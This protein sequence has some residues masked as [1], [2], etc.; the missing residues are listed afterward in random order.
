MAVVENSRETAGD[1]VS[2]K[3]AEPL[4]KFGMW[5]QGTVNHFRTLSIHPNLFQ[6]IKAFLTQF[7]DCDEQLKSTS[8]DWQIDLSWLEPQ[9]YLNCRWTSICIHTWSAPGSVLI[10]WK[11]FTT[12]HVDSGRRT[13]LIFRLEPWKQT[14]QRRKRCTVLDASNELPPV[15]DACNVPISNTNKHNE[16]CSNFTE[17]HKWSTANKVQKVWNSIR[18]LH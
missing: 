8:M 7:P 13:R 6:V 15:L 16:V 2:R 4:S 18:S 11:R 17:F 10:G 9:F 3:T 12:I 14:K 5:H 1:S